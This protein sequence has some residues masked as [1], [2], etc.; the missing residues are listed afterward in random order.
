M[1]YE[2]LFAAVAGAVGIV[3]GALLGSWLTAHLTYNFQKKLLDMQLEAQRKSHEE[4][5]VQCKTVVSALDGLIKS[6]N[7]QM[8]QIKG[9]FVQMRDSLRK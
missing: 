6:F 3:L 1:T 9:Y 5:I 8:N 7:D 4:F 2:A